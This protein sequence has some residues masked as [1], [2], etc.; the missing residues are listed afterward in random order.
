MDGGNVPFVRQQVVQKGEGAQATLLKYAIQNDQAGM[1]E[2]LLDM[3]VS[4]NK[5][6]LEDEGESL[7]PLHYAVWPDHD[8]DLTEAFHKAKDVEY[9]DVF[10]MHQHIRLMKDFKAQCFRVCSFLGSRAR[11]ISALIGSG[12]ILWHQ[13]SA[14]EIHQGKV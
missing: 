3:G 4:P 6:C 9:H 1:V 14:L 10:N 8:H 7:K 13:S 11:I 2:T 5:G 12:T